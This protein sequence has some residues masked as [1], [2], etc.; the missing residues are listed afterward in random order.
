MVEAGL[1]RFGFLGAAGEMRFKRFR[2][3]LEPFETGGEPLRAAVEAGQA[4]RELGRRRL[5][6]FGPFM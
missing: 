5:Q 2:P 3:A 1:P 6:P 4:G